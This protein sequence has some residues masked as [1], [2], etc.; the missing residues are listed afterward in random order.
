MF[1]DPF[2][3]FLIGINEDFMRRTS[4]SVA[5]LIGM[6]FLGCGGSNEILLPTDKLTAEQEAQIKKD[7]ERVADE[8]SQGKRKH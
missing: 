2:K 5:L 3:N 1:S 8:E 4:V 7:D 6:S